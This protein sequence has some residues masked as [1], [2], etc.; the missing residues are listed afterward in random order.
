M[1][2]SGAFWETYDPRKQERQDQLR[3]HRRSRSTGRVC[4]GRHGNVD[5]SGVEHSGWLFGSG[6]SVSGGWQHDQGR[7]G[8]NRQAA[9]GMGGHK[10]GAAGQ[11][12]Y[13]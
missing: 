12:W 10:R 9:A 1:Q 6:A 3:A 7:R 2:L 13:Q 11:D 5:G 4:A 8:A